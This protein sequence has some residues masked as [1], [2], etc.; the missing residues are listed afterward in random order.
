MYVV[1]WVVTS[2]SLVSGYRRSCFR[3]KS[4]GQRYKSSSLCKLQL[5]GSQVNLSGLLGFWN[6]SNVLYCKILEN[7][8]FRKLGLFPTLSII[9]GTSITI[10]TTISAQYYWLRFALFLTGLRMP[11]LPLWRVT[12]EESLATEL[13]STLTEY[14]SPSRIVR[15]LVPLFVAAG[16]SLPKRRLSIDNSSSSIVAR[17]CVD[18]VASRCLAVTIFVTVDG[19][20]DE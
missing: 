7:T 12:N 16:T 8:T 15:M 4:R 11:S 14:R 5:R 3:P 18:F 17:T 2:H 13:T 1:F 6:L 19:W 9:L 20:L 10:T